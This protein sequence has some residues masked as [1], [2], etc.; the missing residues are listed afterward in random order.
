MF[1][2]HVGVDQSAFLN[3]DDNVYG[4]IAKV[5]ARHPVMKQVRILSLLV[6]PL[7]SN[8]VFPVRR[9]EQPDH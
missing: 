7:S 5:D 2:S 4:T 8:I 1:S 3:D 6:L 9:T